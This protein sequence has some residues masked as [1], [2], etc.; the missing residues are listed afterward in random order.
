MRHATFV[1]ALLLLS[2]PSTLCSGFHHASIPTTRA[3]HELRIHTPIYTSKIVR[4]LVLRGKLPDEEEK[5]DLGGA[6]ASFQSRIKIRS[7]VK[8]LARKLVA[9]PLSRASDAI[10]MPNAIASI[11]KDATFAAIED[12]ELVMEK[13]ERTNGEQALDE[14]KQMIS[15][16]I[17][18]A[19]A[20]VEESLET[21]DKSLE[22]ARAALTNAKRESYQAVEAIQVAAI[23]QAEGAAT[24]VA[25]AE[26]VA[27]DEVLGQIYS[28]AMADI[29][30][31]NLSFDDVD[32][33]SSE[34]SPPFLDPDSCLVPGE[35]IVR[36]EKAPENSRRIFAGIDIMAS[37][38]DVWTVSIFSECGIR[39]IAI[40]PS[41]TFLLTC[42][43][44]L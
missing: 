37:V 31:T 27:E 6:S 7:R 39:S 36:V 4:R 14:S 29:D 1:V 18:N 5:A 13:N 30:V 41:R 40:P 43:L 17:E 10:P 34:M 32:Y 44:L 16:I 25:Q 11:L 9:K 22:T 8:A 35:P 21:I 23:A 3:T 20:P 28:S 12:V 19:F 2:D 24:A 26:K 38:D 42:F 15:D 33:D